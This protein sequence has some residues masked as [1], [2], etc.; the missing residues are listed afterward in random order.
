MMGR[1]VIDGNSVYEL[2]ESCIQRKENEKRRQEDRREK[3]EGRRNRNRW[4]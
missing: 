1:L 3:R 4:R 2:D